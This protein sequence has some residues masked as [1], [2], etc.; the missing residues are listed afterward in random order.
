MYLNTMIKGMLVHW[1]WDLSFMMLDDGGGC[2]APKQMPVDVKWWYNY[3][4]SWL[5]PYWLARQSIK[6]TCTNYQHTTG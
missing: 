2:V 4:G 3:P 1:G 6:N 5:R